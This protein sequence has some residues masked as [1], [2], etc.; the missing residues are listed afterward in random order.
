MNTRHNITVFSLLFLLSVVSFAS[1]LSIGAVEISLAQVFSLITEPS[2][3]STFASIVW[4]LRLPRSVLAFA[5][6]AALALAGYLL[7]SI[8]RNPLADPYLF[9]VSSGASFGVVVLISIAGTVGILTMS[10]AAFTGSL[11]SILVLL[12]VAKGALQQQVERLLLTGVALSFLFSAATSLLLYWSDPQAVASVLFWTLGSFSKA[13]WQNIWFALV[14]VVIA[15]VAIIRWRQ[16]LLALLLGD[17]EA[18]SLG[19]NVVVLRRTM[20]IISSLLTAVMVALCGGIGFVGLMVPHVV[21]FFIS[22]GNP[23]MIPAL[24]LS[25][26]IFMLWV[27]IVSRTILDNQELPVGIITS[28]IGSVFFILLLITKKPS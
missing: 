26:G 27:D 4:Q 15:I 11:L 3:N 10:L 8:T 21:R 5:A 18:A 6:G 7:Q 2:Q 22:P 14:V 28:A 23:W 20:L 19:V 12:A 13:N 17:E 9:G 16:P 24:V 25:G 1:A